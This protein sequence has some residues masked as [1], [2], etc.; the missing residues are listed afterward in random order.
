MQMQNKLVFTEPTVEVTRFSVED[1]IT[2]SNGTI[3][4]GGIEMPDHVW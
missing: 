4:S 1:V 3:P 2:T